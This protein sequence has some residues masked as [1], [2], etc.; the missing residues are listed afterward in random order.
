[1]HGRLKVKTNDE[2]ELQKRKERQEKA[3]QFQSATKIL[4]EKRERHERDEELLV[5][6]AQLVSVN[7]DFYTVWNFRRET[8]IEFKNK[9]LNDN[10][11]NIESND[12]NDSQI[13]EKIIAQRNDNLESFRKLCQNELY[14]TANCLKVN[15]KSY[16]V[17]HQRKWIIEMMPNPDLQ[18]E[19]SLCNQFLEID[20]RNF[21]CWDYR[22][23]ISKLTKVNVEEELDFTLQKIKQNFSNFSSWYYRSCLYTSAAN[24]QKFDFTKQWKDEYELVENALFTDP[25][26]QSSWFYH[27][28]L[29]STNYGHNMKHSL[30]SN[31]EKGVQINR[32]V[33]NCSQSLL[34][35]NLSRPIKHRPLVMVEINN[36]F[37]T[38]LEW[39]SASNDLMS[40]IWY[41]NVESFTDNDM[42]S[43]SF[44]PIP[45]FAINHECIE[46]IDITNTETKSEIK[47][48]FVWER[49]SDNL[50]QQFVLDECH[51][52]S[53]RSLL[54]LEPNN[55]WI[56][57]SLAWIDPKSVK[58]DEILGTLI[59]I[60]PL[61]LNYYKDLKSKLILKNE[62]ENSQLKCCPTFQNLNITALYHM[63]R[64]TH[65][66]Y[67]DLSRNNLTKLSK[68]FN[69]L[70]SLQVLI[71]DFNKIYTIDKELKLN[72]LEMLSLNNNMIT[73]I[74]CL[75]NLR[76]CKELKKLIISE[77]PIS[78]E[79]K[80]ISVSQLLLSNELKIINN[81]LNNE[82]SDNIIDTYFQISVNYKSF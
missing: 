24:N 28:W 54:Q 32:I 1:M 68:T 66:Q 69:D 45:T 27:K 62:V 9:L 13:N 76:N 31:Q 21:H 8:I 82:I 30:E 44:K 67:I 78:S 23:F 17:W 60:D 53:L 64:L 19:I 72:K 61:R 6:S 7:P 41:S 51:L 29:V 59:K 71:I 26:D 65:I 22:R 4:F 18:L 35:V 38:Q 77:N 2:K 12:E 33:Y 15:T 80:D 25:S 49:K 5:M 40:N 46:P 73:K 81:E 74:D 57:L 42:I 75:T 50:D 56:N 79:L 70:V 34:I 43:I 39:N 16:C 3:K 20:E 55:K 36:L 14:L 52:E 11:V 47:Q 48:V 10:F 37:Q 63:N 58:L